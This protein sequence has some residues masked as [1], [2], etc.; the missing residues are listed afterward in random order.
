MNLG[1]KTKTG[2]SN[3]EG[4]DKI[5]EFLVLKLCGPLDLKGVHPL[6]N[7]EKMEEMKTKTLNQW[8]KL[9]KNL[10]TWIWITSLTLTRLGNMSLLEVKAVMSIVGSSRGKM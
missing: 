4:Q 3:K 10:R 2:G 1:K 9:K 8:L 7:K 6:S 5:L